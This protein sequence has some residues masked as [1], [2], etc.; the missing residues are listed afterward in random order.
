MNLN[1]RYI[2]AEPLGDVELEEIFNYRSVRQVQGRK[3]TADEISEM[4]SY[5]HNPTNSGFWRMR[6]KWNPE[7][8]VSKYILEEIE[9]KFD[10]KKKYSCKIGERII[11]FSQNEN[12]NLLKDL[13]TDVSRLSTLL[14]IFTYIHKLKKE[15]GGHSIEL[16]GDAITRERIILLDILDLNKTKRKYKE[17]YTIFRDQ[18]YYENFDPRVF[19][20]TI[21]KFKSGYINLDDKI[22]KTISISS[23][24]P[25]PIEIIT[26]FLEKLKMIEDVKIERIFSPEDIVFEPYITYTK[27]VYKEIIEYNLSKRQIDKALSEYE[28]GNYSHCIG[29]IGIIAE[30]ILIQIY[31]TLFREEAKKDLSLGQLIDEIN[32]NVSSLL[33]LR[34]E[35]QAITTAELFSEVNKIL[36]NKDSIDN[37]S[38]NEA[39]LKIMRKLIQYLKEYDKNIKKSIKKGSTSFDMSI[40]P[41]KIRY[42]LNELLRYRNAISHKSRIPIGPYEAIRSVYC[43]ITLLIWWANEK[44]AINWK[45]SKEEIVKKIVEKNN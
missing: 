4:K 25:D 28:D 36:D 13:K 7:N 17:A 15:K 22:K 5:L 34:S 18:I 40:F 32:T 20:G 37:A 1:N 44:N 16:L 19:H 31:E 11:E 24:N 10:T 45:M 2:R 33:K 39:T 30:D 3:L 21:F 35:V 42:S 12:S 23:L 43:A 29:T 9:K 14:I 41:K 26:H 38:I 27:G 6:A 8:S